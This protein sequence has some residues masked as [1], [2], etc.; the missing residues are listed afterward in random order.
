MKAYFSANSKHVAAIVR[1]WNLVVWDA[2]TERASRRFTHKPLGM[3]G[4]FSLSDD[5][6]LALTGTA[7]MAESSHTQFSDVNDSEYSVGYL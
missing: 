4:S 6:K 5:G 3:L 1:L 2:A 7:I